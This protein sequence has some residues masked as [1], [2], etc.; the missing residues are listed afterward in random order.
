MALFGP[1]NIET[2]AL[3]FNV[4]EACMSPK[5]GWQHC[6]AYTSEGIRA[7]PMSPDRRIDKMAQ[8]FLFTFIA[9]THA[10]AHRKS[11]ER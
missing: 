8:T 5:I 6:T 9:R 11:G 2:T 10:C 1:I 7:R 4:F 3:R